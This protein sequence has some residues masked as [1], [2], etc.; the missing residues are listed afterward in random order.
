MSATEQWTFASRKLAPH[1]LFPLHEDLVSAIDA[2]PSEHLTFL[3]TAE[4]K[5]FSPSAFSHWFQHRCDEAK[6]PK[7]RTAHGLRKAAARRLAD[8]GCSANVIAAITGHR[9]LADVS[10]YTRSADQLRMAR[11]GIEAITRTSTYK[12]IEPFVERRKK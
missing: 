12:P 6:L 2:L 10:R 1:Y 8:A 4:G 5:P 3:T 9:S 7:G 11:Q